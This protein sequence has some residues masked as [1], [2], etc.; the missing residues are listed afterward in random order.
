M[1]LASS[2]SFAQLPNAALRAFVKQVEVKKP[3]MEV[4]N[5]I[6][7]NTHMYTA[8]NILLLV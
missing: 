7:P 1:T 4:E 5:K 2:Y 8:L 6:N 3:V